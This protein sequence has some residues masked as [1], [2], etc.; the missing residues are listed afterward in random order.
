[1]GPSDHHAVQIAMQS[2]CAGFILWVAEIMFEDPERACMWD[3][4]ELEI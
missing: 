1:M 4:E 2:F 3:P